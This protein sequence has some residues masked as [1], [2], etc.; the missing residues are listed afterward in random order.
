MKKAQTCP[1]M[2]DLNKLEGMA[3]VPGSQSEF[4]S[5]KQETV[6]ADDVIMRRATAEVISISAYCSAVLQG[7]TSYAKFHTPCT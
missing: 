5:R 4:L 2:R 1:S 6:R 3:S 7:H